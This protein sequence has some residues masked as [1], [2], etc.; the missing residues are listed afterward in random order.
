MASVLPL[1]IRG[2]AR[3]YNHHGDTEDTEKDTDKVSL[4]QIKADEGGYG[5]ELGVRH[6]WRAPL[7]PSPSV[8]QF[9]PY[10]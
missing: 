10:L 1:T 3:D 7:W 6:G 8:L 4:T 2:R 5:K 9:V